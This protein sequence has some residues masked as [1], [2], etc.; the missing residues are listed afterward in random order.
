[1]RRCGLWV[2]CLVIA[3]CGGDAASDASATPTSASIGSTASVGSTTSESGS[4]GGPET[5]TNT[6][7]AS[8]T[9]GTTQPS[10]GPS[11][12]TVADTSS[13]GGDCTFCSGPNERCVDGECETTC[14][15]QLPDPCVASGRACDHISGECADPAG[16][17]VLEGEY[18]PCGG[19]LCGPGS[20]CDDQG[21]CLPFPP[22]AGVAC[23]DDNSCWGTFCSCERNIDCEPP[24]DD[25]LNGPFSTE[26][27]DLEFA[28]DCT[29]WMVTLRSGTDFLRRLTPDGEVTQWAGVSNLN[30]GEVAVLKT[31]TPPPAAAVPL[32]VGSGTVP[33][34]PLTVEGIGEVALSYICCSTCGCV[35][36]PPQGVSRLVEDDEALPLPLVI[37]AVL[38]QSSGPFGNVGADSGPFG[39]TWGIDRV[40]Y[41]GNAEGN[42]TLH[43]A[44]LEM[45]T[46]QQISMFEERVTAA[47][48]L[49][50]AHIMVATLGGAIHRYNV[51]TNAAT[52]VVDVGQDVTNMSFDAFSGLLYV[53]LRD[54]EIITLEPFT[55]VTAT[56]QTMPARGRVTVS[57]NGRLYYSPLGI[58]DAQP[59]SSWDLPDSL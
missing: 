6:D 56:F 45:E 19:Q 44:D 54:F 23:T 15:G 29:A 35:S 36:D 41:V 8:V 57:P 49:T 48:P 3:S 9:S 30:M 12:T 22:C 4:T 20:V 58:L 11:P 34:P 1:M 52:E 14:Q 42:G 7:S 2:V 13:G 46:Q 17:C 25:L 33:P 55:G 38:T 10:T 53:S 31:L 26:I 24:T 16:A 47:A 18:T 39:L 51:I 21:E 40:L 59:I 27:S 32:P 43:T 50:E 28:D 5:N 37:P